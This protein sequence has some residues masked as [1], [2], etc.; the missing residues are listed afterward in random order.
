MEELT[1]CIQAVLLLLMAFKIGIFGGSFINKGAEAMIMNVASRLRNLNPDAEIYVLTYSEKDL[2]KYPQ[3]NIHVVYEDRRFID[4]YWNFRFL[5]TILPL[6]R[7]SRKRFKRLYRYISVLKSLDYM[8]DISGLALS[9]KF[10]SKKNLHQIRKRKLYGWFKLKIAVLPQSMGPFDYKT[11]KNTL[12]RQIRRLLK[13]SSTLYVRDQKSFDYLKG[14][15]IQ[16]HKIKEDTGFSLD[17][18]L[19]K[20]IF[21]TP[22]HYGYEIKNKSVC[23]IPNRQIASR[24]NLE[25]LIAAYVRTFET[26]HDKGYHIYLLNHCS[27]E[28]YYLCNRI[29]MAATVPVYPLYEEYTC[30]ELLRVLEQMDFI[31]ASR[32][33]SIVLAYSKF[34]PAL[35]I[36]WAE[37]YQQLASAFE[38]DEYCMDFDTFINDFSRMDDCIHQMDKEFD[39][40]SIKIKKRMKQIGRASV[41]CIEDVLEGILNHDH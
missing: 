3:M 24:V 40:E 37:K 38:Q 20:K 2:L 12:I 8:I 28:D 17:P 31:I 5:F 11:K 29:G 26:L 18:V 6:K 7:I 4:L 14:I 36:G 10:N 1:F 16:H 30:F 35:L 41:Q 33:H 19:E 27:E 39:N 21:P 15:G 9:S 13:K 23:V 22:L 32:F 34:R 25:D